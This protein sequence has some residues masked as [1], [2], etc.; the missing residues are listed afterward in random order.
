MLR[1]YKYR[2]WAILAVLGLALPGLAQ[3]KETKSFKRDMQVVQKDDQPVMSVS[4]N[5][6]FTSKLRH[7]LSS[8]FTSRILVDIVLR[9]E[10]RKTPLAQDL[11]QFTILYDIW[12]ERYTVREEGPLGKRDFRIYSM[13]DLIKTCGSFND[14]PLTPLLSLPEEMKARIEV[15]ITVNPTSPELRRKVREYLANPDGSG[16]FRRGS[17]PGFF[18]RFSRIFVSE[19][20]IQADMVYTFRSQQISLPT[21]STTE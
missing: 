2:V 19:K 12:D 21:N 9:E 8:G 10:K 18:T 3:V 14:L 15:R 1:R 5:E 7:R 4:F 16:S 13:K 20:D 6:V 17:R 11:V